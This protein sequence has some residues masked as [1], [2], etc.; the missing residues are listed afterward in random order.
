MLRLNYDIAELLFRL[1][2]I[3]LVDDS[4]I[5]VNLQVYVYRILWDRKELLSLCQMA[6]LGVRW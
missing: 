2:A 1:D 3:A 6:F 5:Y 4:D